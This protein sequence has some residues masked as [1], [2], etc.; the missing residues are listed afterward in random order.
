MFLWILGAKM[1]LKIEPNSIKNDPQANPETRHQNITKKLCFQ[2][3]QNLEIMLSLK[4]GAMFH[5]I[6]V[7]KKLSKIL[8]NI[9]QKGIQNQ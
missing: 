1:D 7:F 6:A 5:K 3:L 9:S 8:Q 2:T 4:R